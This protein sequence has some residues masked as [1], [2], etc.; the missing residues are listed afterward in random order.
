MSFTVMNSIFTFLYQQYDIDD[1][2]PSEAL[3]TKNIAK[4]EILSS[5]SFNENVFLR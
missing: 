2:N 4:I 5:F 1:T 3:Q